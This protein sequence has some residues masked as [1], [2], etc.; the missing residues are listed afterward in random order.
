MN[1]GAF[2]LTLDAKRRSEAAERQVGDAM[3]VV[4]YSEDTRDRVRDILN[5]RGDDFQRQYDENEDDLN[6]IENNLDSMKDRIQDLNN[7]VRRCFVDVCRCTLYFRYLR[8]CALYFT[9][10]YQ[11]TSHTCCRFVVDALT[12][13]MSTRRVMTYAAA[14]AAVTAV[15][16]RAVTEPVTARCRRPTRR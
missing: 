3:G 7:M 4:G 8:S 12:G 6:D 5:Q 14:R 15:T 11:L 13:A 1:V 10:R 2:N 16:V 9:V